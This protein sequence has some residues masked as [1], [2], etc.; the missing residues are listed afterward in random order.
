M[1]KILLHGCTGGKTS[2]FGDFL[3]TDLIINYICEHCREEKIGFINLSEFFNINMKKLNFHNT[4]GIKQ[5]DAL[6]YIPG[7][8][9]GERDNPTLKSS[10]WHFRRYFLIG[11]YMAILN[12][13]IAIIGVGST[14]IKSKILQSSIKYVCNKSKVITV[15]DEESKVSL[16]NIGVTKP[17]TVLSDMILSFDMNK[18]RPIEYE[19]EGII[20][21]KDIGQKL[22]LVHYNNNV[23]AMEKFANSTSAF[24]SVHKDYKV[25][26]TSDSIVANENELFDKFKEIVGSNNIVLYKYSDPWKL[27]SLIEKCDCVITTKLHVGIVAIRLGKSVLS[28]PKHAAKTRR[29]YSQINESERCMDINTARVDDI[30]ELLN[31]YHDKGINISEKVYTDSLKNWDYLKQFLDDLTIC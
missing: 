31:K 10:L 2:N 29:L 7:G 30:N 21:L 11:L 27:C 20:N 23:K 19:L 18:M 16:Q 25:V 13:P 15:R 26:V 1:K 24:L 8:Y 17:I 4:M 5:I 28:F 14:T 3:F 22:L 6:I 9:F 12:K